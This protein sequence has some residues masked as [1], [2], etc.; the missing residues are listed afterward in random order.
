M[1]THD[2]EIA[3]Q[4]LGCPRDLLVRAANRH[5]ERDV[6]QTQPMRR[7]RLSDE[8]PQLFASLVDEGLFVAGDGGRCRE[9]SEKSTGH[10]MVPN[11]GGL[12]I[13]GINQSKRHAT[14]E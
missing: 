5:V 7:D 11:N 9:W 13:A 14:R 12:A 1:C 6:L 4:A 2:D 3:R 10:R 8:A